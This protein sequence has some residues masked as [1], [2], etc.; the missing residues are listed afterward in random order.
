MVFKKATDS[1]SQTDKKQGSFTPKTS[2]ISGS[3][4]E[5]GIKKRGAPSGSKKTS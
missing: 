3:K 5:G 4:P 1:K 2:Q